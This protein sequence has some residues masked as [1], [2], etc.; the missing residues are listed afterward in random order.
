MEQCIKKTR[1]NYRQPAVTPNTLTPNNAPPPL[2]DNRPASSATTKG[3]DKGQEQKQTHRAHAKKPSPP[4]QNAISRPHHALFFDETNPN[5]PALPRA[6]P[7][8]SRVIHATPHLPIPQLLFAESNNGVISKA[9]YRL[10]LCLLTGKSKKRGNRQSWRDAHVSSQFDL[11]VRGP[12]CLSSATARAK[13][14]RGLYTWTHRQPSPN[15]GSWFKELGG[16]ATLNNATR[17]PFHRRNQRH[18]RNRDRRYRRGEI[19]HPA[20][21]PPAPARVNLTGLLQFMHS[22][23]AT[24]GTG[25]HA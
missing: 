6:G 25:S 22:T 8:P 14:Q 3:K 24:N 19:G 20:N 10:K 1:V 13:S 17:A 21:I 2:R 4:L 9:I 16:A 5:A 18:R 7:F 12:L 15:I 11:I 23:S